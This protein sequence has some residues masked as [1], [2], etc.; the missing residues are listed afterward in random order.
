MPNGAQHPATRRT[1][2]R[3]FAALC[4]TLWFFLQGSEI[5]QAVELRRYI[6]ASATTGG[7][8][9]PVGVALSTMT[10]VRLESTH[11]II[12]CDV[13]SAGSGENISMLREKKAQF[14]ILQGL[15]GA[16]AWNGAGNLRQDGPQTYLRSITMLWQ[17]VEHFIIKSD[18]VKTGDM[19]DLTA[20]KAKASV[21][22]S[23]TIGNRGFGH[24]YSWSG[25]AW[26]RMTFNRHRLI[27]AAIRRQSRMALL[28]A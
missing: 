3:L 8:Y 23:E 11:N 17:N 16:W 14:A 13:S 10:K 19:S 12:L 5:L 27:T 18:F 2:L 15:Y 6:L 24:V 4:L 1:C 28:T 25:L 20:L 7:T 26:P 22:W 21:A 9:Y